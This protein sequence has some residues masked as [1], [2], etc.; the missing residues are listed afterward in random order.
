MP[1]QLARRMTKMDDCIFLF[2]RDSQSQSYSSKKE[3][4]K[5]EI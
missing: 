2:N 1:I 4:N 5:K 3:T